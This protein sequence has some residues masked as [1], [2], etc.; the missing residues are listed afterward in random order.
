VS[1][2]ARHAILAAALTVLSGC[3]LPPPAPI[4]WHPAPPAPPIR[5]EPG[6]LWPGPPKPPPTLLDL[7]AQGVRTAVPAQPSRRGGAGLCRTPA[8]PGIALGLCYKAP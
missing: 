5:A 2:A 6:D 4:R 8:S 7:Q 1:D 3:A